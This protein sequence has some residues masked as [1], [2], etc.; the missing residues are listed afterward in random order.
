MKR[1]FFF[2][3]HLSASLKQKWGF[4]LWKKRKKSLEVM[5]CTGGSL[6]YISY[7]FQMTRSENGHGKWPFKSPLLTMFKLS[8]E[9][10]PGLFC[11]ALLRPVIGPKDLHHLYLNQLDTKP[12]PIT[13]W[14]LAF[15]RARRRLSVFASSYF[16]L[17][18]LFA[19]LA[20]PLYLPLWLPW[21]YDTNV[22]HSKC[23]KLNLIWTG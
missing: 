12:R 2:T 6:S 21:F 9:S 16:W 19:F 13:T 14:S 15:S 4:W 23:G 7:H 20:I 11:F 18:D 8:V 10:N 22:N 3:W 1:F 17:I 5:H